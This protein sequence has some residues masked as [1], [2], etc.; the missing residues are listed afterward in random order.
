MVHWHGIIDDRIIEYFFSAVMT[1]TGDTVFNKTLKSLGV[2]VLFF[3][4]VPI[5]AVLAFITIIGVP[6]GLLLLFNYVILILL[7]TVITS[8]V[9]AHWLNNRFNHKW[10]Y[11]RLV[12]AALAVFIVLKL[13]SFLP[14][15]GWLIALLAIC[16]AFGAILQNI[17]WKH[18]RQVE[19]T[20]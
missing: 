20:A 19:A 15:L 18:T 10:N 5:A 2:G 11:W 4:A 16:M 12:F 17:H 14:F 9:T 6:V 7:A 1:K 3:I 13:V 8:V